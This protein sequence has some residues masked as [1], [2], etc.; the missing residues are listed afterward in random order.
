MCRGKWEISIIFVHFSEG[1]RGRIKEG[2]A[3]DRRSASWLCVWGV[4]SVGGGVCAK[5]VDQDE[6][7]QG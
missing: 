7:L 3:A 6:G 2:E 5:V 1:E 4:G